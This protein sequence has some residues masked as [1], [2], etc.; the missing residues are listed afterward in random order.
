MSDLLAA[1]SEG[2]TPQSQG[3]RLNKAVGR[4]TSGPSICPRSAGLTS[5]N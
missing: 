1:E 3:L 5:L 4:T 2:G